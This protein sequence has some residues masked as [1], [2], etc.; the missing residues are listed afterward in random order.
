MG[1]YNSAKKKVLEK[2]M[3]STGY[4]EEKLSLKLEGY[5]YD[6]RD[7]LLGHQRSYNDVAENFVAAQGNELHSKMCA[8]HS[9]S[10]LA[11]N[12][13]AC[14]IDKKKDLKIGDFRGCDSI[15]FEKKISVGAHNAQANIDLYVNS[16][17]CD[18]YIESKFLEPLTLTKGKFSKAYRNL[19]QGQRSF[20]YLMPTLKEN[21]EGEI[22][23]DAMYFD[24]AQMIKHYLAI[25]KNKNESK[26][27]TLIYL[28]WTPSNVDELKTYEIHKKELAVFQNKCDE[29]KLET[30]ITFKSMTYAELFDEW[31]NNPNLKDHVAKL[32]GRYSFEI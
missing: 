8:V 11:V 5:V 22:V 17:D 25:E 21:A 6:V 15:Q 14:F 18:I 28:Y 12:A 24:I 2:F 16:T 10:A 3:E 19:K 32:R 31:D 30:N 1:N 20:E 26:N 9:S 23:L 7:N 29:L 4:G 27:T 13:F